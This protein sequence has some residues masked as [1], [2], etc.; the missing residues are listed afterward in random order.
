MHTVQTSQRRTFLVAL[1]IA[2]AVG[3]FLMTTALGWGASG[4]QAAETPAE[5]PPEVGKIEVNPSGQTY[6]SALVD[7]ENPPVLVQAYGDNGEIGYVYNDELAGPKISS[8]EEAVEYMKSGKAQERTTLTLYASD[9]K[10]PIGTFTID[11]AIR[12][13]E[14]AAK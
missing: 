5:R 1:A 13:Q 8:P 12:V 7:P 9:G 3:A 10:T 2:T 6:G 4:S 11:P 14:E